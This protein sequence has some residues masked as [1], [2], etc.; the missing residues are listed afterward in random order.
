[1]RTRA[2]RIPACSGTECAFGKSAVCDYGRQHGFLRHQYPDPVQEIMTALHVLDFLIS[3]HKTGDNPQRIP[4][5]AFGQRE[6]EKA[7]FRLAVIR[8]IERFSIDCREGKP[9]FKIY[10]YTPALSPDGAHAGIL[11]YLRHNDISAN[12]RLDF[13]TQDQLVQKSGE[14]ERYRELHGSRVREAA[15]AAS[16]L[17][18]Y[19]EHEEFFLLISNCLIPVVCHVQDELRNMAHY[20]LWHLKEMIKAGRCRYSALLKTVQTLDEDWK[21]G[22]C[23]RCAANP[24]PDPHSPARPPENYRLAELEDRFSQWMENTQIPFD[25]VSA[26]RLIQDFGDFYDNLLF[27][28]RQ[29]LEHNPRNIKA[30]H[31]LREL[32]PDPEKAMHTADLMQVASLDMKDPQVIRFY[33]TS[34][35]D[36]ALKSS[37][38]DLM[39][40]E[41]G[42]LHT[43]AGEQWLCREARNLNLPSSLAEMLQWR[44]MLN[45]LSQIDFSSRNTRL[46]QILK[47]F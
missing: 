31:V 27:R 26:D 19:R 15:A 34:Q 41:Y 7:L 13:R 8:L 22:H 2:T 12:R 32:S 18:N 6:A 36:T 38:F 40:N 46:K 39:D 1:M 47:E 30:L 10:G 25:A 44:A 11:H 5:S 42:T 21:C 16:G 33:E 24:G 37:M 28:S 23:D 35:A 20:R 29:I 3:G 45:I 4:L 9:V 43:P 17:Q 14:I